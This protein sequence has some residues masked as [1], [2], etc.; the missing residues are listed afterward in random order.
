MAK[1]IAVGNYRGGSKSK[2][3]GIHAKTKT[4]RSK[5]AKHYKKSYVGQGK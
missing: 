2:R 4:S 5:N 1:G 3:P